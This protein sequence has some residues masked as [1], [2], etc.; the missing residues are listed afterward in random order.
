M[1]TA[2]L[3]R[4]LCA[5]DKSQL[6]ELING[7]IFA[8]SGIFADE[9]KEYRGVPVIS[10]RN[11]IERLTDLVEKHVFPVLPQAD[12]ECCT[13]CG[14]D[15]YGMVENILSDKKNRNDCKT[16][17]RA[18]LRLRINS[19]E[20]KIVPFVQDILKDVILALTRKLKGCEKGKIE[21]TIDE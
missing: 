11:E 15:C 21:I 19:K 4:I 17:R 10:S 3:P 13:A 14:T 5:K 16:D 12:P 20:I 18:G 2:A 1:K 9:N 7:T 8:I 6:D